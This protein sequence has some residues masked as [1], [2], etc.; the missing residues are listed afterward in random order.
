MFFKRSLQFSL[1]YTHT[2]PNP[3]ST[4][5]PPAPGAVGPCGQACS[6]LEA[7]QSMPQHLSTHSRARTPTCLGRCPGGRGET[8][9]FRSGNPLSDSRGLLTAERQRQGDR[10]S[11]FGKKQVPAAVPEALGTPYLLPPPAFPI[12][13]P[14]ITHWKALLPCT[15]MPFLH[16]PPNNEDNRGGISLGI[17]SWLSPLARVLQPCPCWCNP[18]AKHLQQWGGHTV[19]FIFPYP[20]ALVKCPSTHEK[21]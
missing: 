15:P 7:R 16:G 11:R 4:S 13:A 17:L 8:T 20:E 21:A 9:P 1:F 5:L 3:Q 2:P 12:L 6:R 10:F 19:T 18:S 14:K